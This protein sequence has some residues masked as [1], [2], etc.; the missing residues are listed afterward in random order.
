MTLLAERTWE[1]VAGLDS[2]RVIALLPVGSTEAHGPHLPLGTDV[3]IGQAMA[4]AGAARLTAAGFHPLV[5]PPIAYSVTE[6][7]AG[8][9]GTLSV[10]PQTATALLVDI[11]RAVAAM[12]V[13][14][15]A[16]A[17]AHLEPAHIRCLHEAAALL[18]EEGELR[19]AFPDI[20]RKPWALRLGD[21]L[22]SGACH[23]G[24]Y[25]GS[26]VMA[27]RGDLVREELRKS[28]A[29]NPRSLSEAIAEGIGT[30]EEAGGERA[31]FGWPA[32]ATAEEGAATRLTLGDILAEAVL[33]EVAG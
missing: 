16:F 17:N 2:S 11:G 4:R 33:A 15:L 7:A 30:F 10:R 26:V 5:L 13:A 31:Y 19:V 27:E 3:I 20:T 18:R 23:A 25:E 32:E 6:F 29:P 12:G 14:A 21:E 9:S 22:R 24:R 1:E 28:L 8:F